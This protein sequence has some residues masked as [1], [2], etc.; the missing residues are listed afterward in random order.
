MIRLIAEHLDVQSISRLSRVCQAYHKA[1]ANNAIFWK[2]LARERGVNFKDGLSPGHLQ[3]L[4][5][6]KEFQHEVYSIYP[7]NHFIVGF[8]PGYRGPNQE[9]EL[10]RGQ[11]TM[12]QPE[13]QEIS[14]K[15]YC[16]KLG[17]F[18]DDI[19]V[20]HSHSVQ[21]NETLRDAYSAH[22]TSIYDAVKKG[23]LI[24]T[25]FRDV[26]DKDRYYFVYTFDGEWYVRNM[27][28]EGQHFLPPESREM[29]INMQKIRGPLCRQHLRDIYDKVTLNGFGPSY[30]GEY[31]TVGEKGA[32]VTKIHGKAT[33]DW[34]GITYH[35]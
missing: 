23:D 17:D 14:A 11:P 6:K 9:Q 25:G 2:Q 7:G 32:R 26:L 28:G 12:T 22:L 1:L 27:K 33:P 30:R 3:E 19:L 13:V 16:A 4:L 24:D 35:L 31:Y 18:F 29:L 21:H 15:G 10:H 20:W 34:S 5:Y 8:I